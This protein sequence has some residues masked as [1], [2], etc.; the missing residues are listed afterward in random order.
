MS[1][2]LP[3]STNQD[4]IREE[5]QDSNASPNSSDAVQPQRLIYRYLIESAGRQREESS[6]ASSA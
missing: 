4:N 2:T 6:A 1:S 3:S 5:Y